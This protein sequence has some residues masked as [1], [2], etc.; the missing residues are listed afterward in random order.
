MKTLTGYKSLLL[1]GGLLLVCSTGTQLSNIRD[2]ASPKT[3][4]DKKDTVV[5]RCKVGPDGGSLIKDLAGKLFPVLKSL[6]IM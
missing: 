3:A 4:G 2:V 5:T 1:A 6:N